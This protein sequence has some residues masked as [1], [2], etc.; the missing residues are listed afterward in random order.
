[1]IICDL[2]MTLRKRT[3]IDHPLT[4][5]SQYL[6]VVIATKKLERKNFAQLFLSFPLAIHTFHSSFIEINVDI[7]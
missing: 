3:S 2:R 4:F 6:Q 7:C 5:P 1:M